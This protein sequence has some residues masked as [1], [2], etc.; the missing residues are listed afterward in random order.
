MPEITAPDGV[1]LHFEEW[2]QPDEPAVVLL[3][4]FTADLRSW[5]PI[6]EPLSDDYRVIALDLRGHGLSSAPA[7]EAAYTMDAF[8]GDVLHL[9]DALNIELCG[10]VGSSF[11]GMIAAQVGV[12]WPERLAALCISDASAAYEDSR[13]AEAYYERERRIDEMCNVVAKW[14]TAHLGKQ[15]AASISDEFLRAATI[16]RYSR[17][18]SEAFLGSAN[19][20]RNRPNLLPELQ[21]RLTMPVLVCAGENDHVRSA[22]EVIVSELPSA[23]Y[24]LF[25]E[26]GHT[27]PVHR[28]D[29]FVDALIAFLRDVEDGKPIPG[30]HEL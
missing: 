14:G 16:R 21:H 20:R 10:L 26:S 25:R 9:L 18:S 12:N 8:A 2:G 19:V 5:M 15:L 1:T 24:V 29:A 28:P 17:M 13:Y 4:G 30:R 27:V 3:H 7:D 22:S 11:G 23:R 6:I